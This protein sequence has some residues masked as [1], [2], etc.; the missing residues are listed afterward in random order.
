MKT[1]F[2]Y[3]DYCELLDAFSTMVHAALGK[4]LIT[5]VLYG[6]VARRAAHIESDIDVLI[7]H[8]DPPLACH[9]RMSPVLAI[10]RDMRQ[11]EL[12][13][14]YLKQG[15]EPYLNVVILSQGEGLVMKLWYKKESANGRELS[16]YT[17]WPVRSG[18][19]ALHDRS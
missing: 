7:I 2:G 12:W 10:I 16:G 8:R 19:W 5:M 3:T 18:G 6:S 9:E 14:R 15:F 1:G 4:E 17:R 13:A 11:S